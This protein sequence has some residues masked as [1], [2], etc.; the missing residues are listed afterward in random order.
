MLVG[1][2]DD[3]ENRGCQLLVVPG[4]RIV[5]RA[6]EATGLL[7]LFTIADDV[8]GALAAAH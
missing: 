6:L 3:A 8:T 1:A 7:Q 5:K 4:S 2:K